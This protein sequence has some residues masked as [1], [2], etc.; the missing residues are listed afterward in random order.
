MPTTTV[1]V[2]ASTLGSASLARVGRMR[3]RSNGSGA[4]IDVVAMLVM[5]VSSLDTNRCSRARSGRADH[6]AGL[7]TVG[8]QP[9]GRVPQP[10]FRRGGAVAGVAELAFAAHEAGRAGHRPHEAHA[11]VDG[12]VG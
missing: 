7:R 12:G 6:H 3:P 10:A 9:S 1:A 2:I 11:H 5:N 4:G 8:D